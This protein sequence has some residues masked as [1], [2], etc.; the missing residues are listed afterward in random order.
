M[1]AGIDLARVSMPARPDWQDIAASL[2]YTYFRN[3]DGS[4]AWREDVAYQFSS[5]LVSAIGL[6]AGRLHKLCLD[7]VGE[8]VQSPEILETFGIPEAMW[9]VVRAS[10]ERRDPFFIGRF[11]FA[12]VD[13]VIKMI[14][15]NADTPATVPESTVV[16]RR[17][18]SDVCPDRQQ[19]SWLQ[20]TTTQWLRK[21]H[22]PDRRAMSDV[23]HVVPYPGC[24]EDYAHARTYAE[25][26][27]DA[28]MTAILAEL[29]DIE[30]SAAG[31]LLH[32]GRI[33][34]SMIRMYPWELMF[35]EEGSRH[36]L[37]S[38]C[39][40]LSPP[41][42]ALLSNK[43]LLAALWERNPGHPNLIPTRFSPEG[44]DNY[45]SKPLCSRGGENVS[46][47]IDG[48]NVETQ[49]G[50]YGAYRRVYQEFVDCRV[51]DAYAS[52]GAWVVGEGRF[53][54]ITMRESQGMIVKDISAIVPHF[55]G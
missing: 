12:L 35:R 4:L 15:Y 31:E 51:G 3:E 47:F 36:L 49:A 14:E 5:G 30:V 39:R 42:T 52:I 16:Q 46:I 6:A 18:L 40:F 27:K 54:G 53:A 22:S 2:D 25:W 44:M 17:W 11:D 34:K 38:S 45:V 10:W 24:T 32:K 43:A 29:A 19:A 41:W 7:F 9:P 48:E 23:V 50:T 26:L 1:A 55:I 37:T 13:G 20:S 33:I 28:G 8:A 21:L